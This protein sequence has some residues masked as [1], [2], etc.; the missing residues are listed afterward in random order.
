MANKKKRRGSGQSGVDPNEIRRQKLE[1]RRE[2][3]AAAQREKEKRERRERFVRRGALVVLGAGAFWFIFVRGAA[4]DEIGGHTIEHFS[5]AGANQHTDG[6]VDYSMTPPVSGEHAGSPAPCGIH[7]TQ[8]QNELMVHT[9]EHGA[10]G[11]L[12]DPTLDLEQ[13][14]TLEGIAG[15][16]DDHTFSAPYEGMETP[17]SVV[18]WAQNMRLDSVDEAAINEFIDTFRTGGDAPEPQN[19]CPNTQNSPFQPEGEGDSGST[20]ETPSPEASPTDKS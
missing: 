6:T 19:E 1:A 14:R 20:S 9:L 5:T 16:F 8:I 12:Y 11:L 13:I 2:A 10:I 7:A 18:A 4:P 3:K 15:S 17:I